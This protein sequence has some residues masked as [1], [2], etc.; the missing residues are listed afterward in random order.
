MII[1]DSPIYRRREHG[2]RMREERHRY[3]E[4]RYGFRSDGIPSMEFLYD[5]LLAELAVRQHL[6]WRIYR[7]WYGF[8]W[9]LRPWKARLKKERP[10]SR[11][12][13]LEG[14]WIR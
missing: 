2:E 1:L 9:H 10:P 11:F 13:I 6:R 4:R 8:R 14:D 5:G 7:P 12:N 3:F